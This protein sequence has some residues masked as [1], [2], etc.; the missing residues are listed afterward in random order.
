MIMVKKFFPTALRSVCLVGIF[1]TIPSALQSGETAVGPQSPTTIELTNRHAEL[2]AHAIADEGDPERGQ[3]L[4][5]DEKRLRC[6][7]CHA[8]DGKSHAVGP[9]LF[10]VGN[11][12]D[13]RGLVESILNPSKS[14]AIGYGTTIV[15]TDDGQ[16]SHGILQR[17]TDKGLELLDA[18]NRTIQIPT[19]RVD[20]QWESNASMMPSGLDVGL[21][22]QEF[23]DLVAYLSTLR[24]SVEES[25]TPGV[26]LEI[27]RASA[28]VQLI[29]WFDGMRFEHPVWLGQVPS[30]NDKTMSSERFIILEQ[31]G[32]AYLLDNAR[33]MWERSLLFDLSDS[34]RVGGAT[35]LLG[36]AFH[37]K[38]TSNRRY[39]I[40]YQTLDNKRIK[41]I[42]EERRMSPDMA[43]DDGEAVR[44]LLSVDAVTQDHNGG[45]VEFGPDGFLY[46]GM[47]DSGPQED[48]QGHG[49]D[50]GTLLGK[51]LR[52]DVD[53]SDADVPYAIPMDN[54]FAGDSTERREIWAFGFREPWRFTFDSATAD[55]WVGDVGQNRFEEVAIVRAGENHGWNVF[56]GHAEH[57]NRFRQTNGGYVAPVF[58]YSR[59]HGVSITGG[60]V[61]RGSE[62]TQMNGWYI[63]G[64]FESRRIWA[65]RQRDRV[66]TDIVEIG[67]APSRIVSFC[68]DLRNELLLLGYDDGVAYRM[69]L[70]EVDTS[71]LL[72][73]VV[74]ETS[75]KSPVLWRYTTST[76]SADWMEEDFDDSDWQLGPGG[77]GTAGT[78]GAVVKTDWDTQQIWIRR[79]FSGPDQ[80]PPDSTMALLVHHDEDVAV[81]I[82]G[83]EAFR[84][85][86]WTSSYIETPLPEAVVKSLR[87]SGNV[88]AVHCRQN[89]G[90][91][92]I[93]V[94][95]VAH[96]KP[97]GRDV[98][99][100]HGD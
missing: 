40:K 74:A 51:I 81:Y 4:F 9:N 76:P 44:Q 37:P 62:S 45:C 92:Y 69:R 46:I 70:N 94:G 3:S 14:I 20:A 64:D 71:L 36:M 86:K 47:G 12:F 28:D 1:V 59:T 57:S 11:K 89:S 2:L 53:R 82:N 35:G 72:T 29:P 84:A 90:G 85:P 58:S 66:L 18:S 25:A 68:Q 52:I 96:S 100:A 55:L 32:R 60:Y 26:T 49:Q 48:P 23:T 21:S 39:V 7:T 79:T 31:S 83:I 87:P 8:T 93:D 10:A 24:Q 27:P 38:F 30:S 73:Q 56:E 17:V 97:S 78:P 65:L 61:Y 99:N 91:Q 75:Q 41:T 15:E 50:R 77:F 19:D 22:E 43:T 63:T 54:P 13:K 34:V 80:L 6:S 42:V 33:G 88:I 67:R 98:T 5:R 95:I 16:L